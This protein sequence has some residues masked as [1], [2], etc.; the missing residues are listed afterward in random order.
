MSADTVAP[1]PI[2]K[3]A[4]GSCQSPHKAPRTSPWGFIAQHE[5]QVFVWAGDVTYAKANDLASLARAYEA[6]PREYT[7]FSNARTVVG[8]WDDHDYGV[9]D[10]GAWVPHREARRDM[11]LDFLKVPRDSPRRQRRGVYAVHDF[12]AGDALVRVIAL[13]TRF[14]RS[15]HV[16]PSV[17]HMFEG[18]AL[19]KLSALAAAAVRLATAW[20]GLVAFRDA[21]RRVLS[22]EQWAWLDDALASSRASVTILVSSVQVLTTNP[23]L[24]SFG[25]FPAER[26]RLL[27]VLRKHRPRGLV[28]VSGD[29]HVADLLGAGSLP[30]E[31]TSSGLTHSCSDSVPQ[32]ICD[33]AW[34]GRAANRRY[35]NAYLGRNYGI[36]DIDW[37]NRTLSVTMFDIPDAVDKTSTARLGFTRSL[38]APFDA[39]LPA[40]DPPGITL[41]TRAT[42][43][44]WGLAVVSAVVLLVALLR[45]TAWRKAALRRQQLRL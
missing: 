6:L 16:V 13:D 36:I 24:E 20:T 14:D 18:S 2:T 28:I 11:F 8:T 19:S 4:F 43:A 35:G 21:E 38:D 34:S 37:A 40:G 9:N 41:S 26:A 5:P 23:S 32:F 22:E 12:G 45:L 33:L 10:G 1:G 31:A 15:D 17:G 29:V 44:V 42:A 7:E 3:L 39:L 27:G 25:H 30:L